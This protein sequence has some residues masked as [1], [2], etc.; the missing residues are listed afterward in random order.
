[1]NILVTGGCGYGS[2]SAVETITYVDL[3]RPCTNKTMSFMNEER[4]YNLKWM[5]REVLK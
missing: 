3:S 4:Y 1:M 2:G 5:Q